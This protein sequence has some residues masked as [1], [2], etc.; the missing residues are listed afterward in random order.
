MIYRIVCEDCGEP[1]IARRR[2]GDL[3]PVPRACPECGSE[4]YVVPSDESE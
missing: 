3:V 4:A 1:R 2:D